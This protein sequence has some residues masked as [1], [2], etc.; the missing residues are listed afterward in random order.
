MARTKKVKQG[1]SE[2]TKQASRELAE[3][4]ASAFDDFT[5]EKYGTLNPPDPYVTPTG[6]RPLDALLGGGLMS[7][8]MIC[9]SS[10]PETGKSTIAYQFARQF[11]DVHE[12][13][14]VVYF[15]VEGTGGELEK[16]SYATIFQE[17][18]A[19]T[20]N[21]VDDPRFK[22]NRRPYNIKDFFEYLD[23]LIEKKREIQ[24]RTGSEIKILFILDSVTAL[25]YSRIDGVED[26]DK[27][28]GKRAAELSF[29]LIKWK[30]NFAYDRVTMISIDQ[31]KAAM[32]IKGQYEQA[33]EKTVGTWRN[34]KS[35][36]GVWT[37]Q[38]AISQWL[39]FSKGQEINPAKFPALDIDGW[40]VNV[41]TE[42][43]KN[44]TGKHQ[45]SLVFDKRN[46][47]NKFWSEFVFVSSYCPTEVSFM[48]GNWE[49]NIPLMI[50]TE[51]AYS[52]LEVINP[53][54]GEVEYSSKKFFKKNA[55]KMY[56]ED[57]EFRKWFDIA[58]DYS[59]KERISNGLLKID[60]NKFEELPIGE[61]EEMV[62]QII[63][64]KNIPTAENEKIKK[65]GRKKKEKI[66]DEQVIAPTSND[67]EIFESQIIEE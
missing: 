5:I 21:L 16:N 15:D 53:L 65:R 8:S 23:G 47:L 7:S 25:S 34:T 51:G 20:F 11:L 35:A 58:V 56:D 57:L 22:Y 43:N 19:E 9:F 10:T 29:Y 60:V 6:I 32:S 30:Q 40:M 28:P 54:T 48:R 14:L 63:E 18:R 50:K 44:T 62:E 13:G 4:L 45:L 61:K 12:N 46:G 55:K 66:E 59:C 27:I 38:H 33:D 1:V 3:E 26:F 17:S 49:P 36:T 42:K 39:F 31:L 52:V 67:E 37:F 2:V 64:E 24:A 41:V